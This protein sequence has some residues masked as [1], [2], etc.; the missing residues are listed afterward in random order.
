V[1]YY[2]KFG[3]VE[4]ETTPKVMVMSLVNARAVLDAVKNH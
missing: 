3:F 2:A 1:G 4:V